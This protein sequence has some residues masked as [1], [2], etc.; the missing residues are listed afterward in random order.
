MKNLTE[1]I[2]ESLFLLE[3]YERYFEIPP[4]EYEVIMQALE[5]YKDCDDRKKNEGNGCPSLK[6]LDMVIEFMKRGKFK[7]L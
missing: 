7:K 1:F 2:N 3:K 5:A 4:F 6:Q